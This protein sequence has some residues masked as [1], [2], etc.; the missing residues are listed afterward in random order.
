MSEKTSLT[1]GDGKIFEYEE[2]VVLI[3]LYFDK[4][5]ND[6]SIVENG[7]KIF[8]GGCT[9]EI[10][11]AFV[12]YRYEKQV[13]VC[14]DEWRVWDVYLSPKEFTLVMLG[15]FDSCDDVLITWKY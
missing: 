4:F 10:V 1:N 9:N 12:K 11:K 2:L 5:S 3:D 6:V 7:H 13:N 8:E 14:N 15:G